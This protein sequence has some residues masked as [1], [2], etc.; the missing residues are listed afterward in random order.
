MH[1][2]L[3]LRVATLAVNPLVSEFK[4]PAEPINALD[5]MA[6]PRRQ[7]MSVRISSAFLQ[8]KWL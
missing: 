1:N 7:P 4:I 2:V 5:K 6:A 8:P 3:D